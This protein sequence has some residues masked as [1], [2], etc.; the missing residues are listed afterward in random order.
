MALSDLAS[1]HFIV[2]P[3]KVRSHSIP[4]AALRHLK[5]LIVHLANGSDEVFDLVLKR[6]N[7]FVRLPPAS[8]LNV[9]QAIFIRKGLFKLSYAAFLVEHQNLRLKGTFGAGGSEAISEASRSR[10]SLGEAEWW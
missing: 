10:T 8:L 2:K 3:I 1:G 7:P 5:N 9:E 6:R 4:I